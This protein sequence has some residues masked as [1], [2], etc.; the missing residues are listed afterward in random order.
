MTNT[1][2]AINHTLISSLTQLPENGKARRRSKS[3]LPINPLLHLHASS[4]ELMTT[5]E[6]ARDDLDAY[7]EFCRILANHHNANREKFR[8]FSSGIQIRTLHDY[9][10]EKAPSEVVKTTL[11]WMGLVPRETADILAEEILKRIGMDHHGREVLKSIQR[12]NPLER[13]ITYLFICAGK[14][15]EGGA[16][17]DVIH[18]TAPSWSGVTAW[19]DRALHN[20]QYAKGRALP[21]WTR[22]ELVAAA[23]FVAM[24]VGNIW[25]E[26]SFARQCYHIW[27]DDH[28]DTLNWESGGLLALDA[29]VAVATAYGI[30]SALHST[31]FSTL[32]GAAVQRVT[33]VRTRSD[34]DRAVDTYVRM[35]FPIRF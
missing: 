1:L 29:V 14:V 13:V 23:G 26:V 17:K 8:Q 33:Q 25:R 10:E 20:T 2:T 22:S 27:S 28:E 6:E 35:L 12:S 32:S 3:D 24:L 16:L 34:L 31:M 30:H 19:V 5:F 7:Q 15:E 21:D 4:S 18:T 11:L 9:N